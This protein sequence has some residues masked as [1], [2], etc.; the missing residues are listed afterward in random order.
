[1]RTAQR[2]TRERGRRGDRACG[3]MRQRALS[4]SRMR[5]VREGVD[6]PEDSGALAVGAVGGTSPLTIPTLWPCLVPFSDHGIT[7]VCI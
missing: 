1:M 3:R 5:T 7:F 4:G 2:A 6:T